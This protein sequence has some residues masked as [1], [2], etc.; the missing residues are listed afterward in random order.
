VRLFHPDRFAQQPDKRETY[1]KLTGAINKARDEG[2]IDLLRD[3]GADPSTFV[4][5]QG[6]S[7][8]DF[9]DETEAKSLRRLYATLQ[10]EIVK[11]LDALNE[12][13][14]SPDFQLYVLS[15]KQPG[16]LEQVA[17]DQI[18][19]LVIEIAQLES[20]AVKLK[21]EI[22]ELIGAGVNSVT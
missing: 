18:K 22:D 4:L 10:V 13:H 12:L 15:E 2:D 6:W 21:Q 14:E 1:E 5:R 17:D 20:E 3:I 19:A 7:G 16:L 11:M 8:L 9:D